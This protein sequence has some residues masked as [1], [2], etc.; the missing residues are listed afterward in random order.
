M[1]TSSATCAKFTVLMILANLRAHD[2]GGLATRRFLKE[3]SHDKIVDKL[4]ST[5]II[6]DS[7][8]RKEEVVAM[9]QRVVPQVEVSITTDYVFDV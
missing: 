2:I 5:K 3:H 8:A 7:E 6:L 9:L 1:T 4:E